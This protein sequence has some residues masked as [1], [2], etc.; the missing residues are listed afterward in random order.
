[1]I[2]YTPIL[3]L[4]FTHTYYANGLC[5]D[6][7]AEPTAATRQFIK[8]Y[9]LLVRNRPAGLD[10]YAP[11][12][13]GQLLISLPAILSLQWKL[14]PQ[15]E[16]FFY[17]TELPPRPAGSIFYINNRGDAWKKTAGFKRFTTL[18]EGGASGLVQ[19]PDDSSGVYVE[20][21]AMQFGLEKN[22]QETPLTPPP[23]TDDIGDFTFDPSGPGLWSLIDVNGQPRLKFSGT[24]AQ[25]VG[26]KVSYPTASI[27]RSPDFALLDL[28]LPA[29]V[30]ANPKIYTLQ[31]Q[32]KSVKWQYLI[33]AA[34]AT[35]PE[36]DH[37]SALKII[38]NRTAYTASVS[39]LDK[40]KGPGVANAMAH[41]VWE[42]MRPAFSAS[43]KMYYISSDN[44]IPYQEAPATDITIKDAAETT[45]IITG[46][47]NPRIEEYG[48]HVAKDLDITNLLSFTP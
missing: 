39:T 8:D 33:P 9:R 42:R 14:R 46:L 48:L 13:G 23:A 4:T 34:N 16:D 10:V 24:V 36:L 38:V 31:F 17:F 40:N 20:N 28:E 6:L 18:Y 26:V 43:T 44:P 45:E 35:A 47:R 11:L 3:Q 15:S 27:A 37:A 5:K 30:A 2:R 25:P 12:T 21:Y 22:G 7:A 1:M 29:A 41:L 19:P 32:A